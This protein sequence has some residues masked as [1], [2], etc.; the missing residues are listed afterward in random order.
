[1]LLQSLVQLNRREWMRCRLISSI[2][3]CFRR[4]DAHNTKLARVDSWPSVSFLRQFWS[5]RTENRSKT[6][7][8]IGEIPV[9]RN[10]NVQKR[11]WLNSV[12]VKTD[13]ISA[14]ALDFIAVL[15]IGMQIHYRIGATPNYYS[16]ILDT[17]NFVYCM[18]FHVWFLILHQIAN[19]RAS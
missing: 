8:E 6:I 11:T 15:V 17:L 5:L 12:A 3:W 16:R 19:E 9:Y 18:T 2:C 14:M 7:N 13:F 4:L 1:M 10:N